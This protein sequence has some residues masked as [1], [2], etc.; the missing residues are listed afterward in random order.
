MYNNGVAIC[1]Y[2]NVS[3]EF[4]TLSSSGGS[5]TRSRSNKSA[6]ETRKINMLLMAKRDRIA[7]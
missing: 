3:G 5:Q 4:N 7:R 6:N 1:Q 2:C